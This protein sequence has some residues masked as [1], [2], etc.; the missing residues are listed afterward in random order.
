MKN[1]DYSR[2]FKQPDTST[3]NLY[4]RSYFDILVVLL[5]LTVMSWLFVIFGVFSSYIPFWICLGLFIFLLLPFLIN[6]KI[7]WRKSFRDGH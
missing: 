5:V 7:E 3:K 4:K 2:V 1:N 6:F